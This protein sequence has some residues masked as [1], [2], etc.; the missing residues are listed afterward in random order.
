MCLKDEQIELLGFER[1]NFEIF[2]LFRRSIFSLEK[3]WSI[4]VFLALIRGGTL[5]IQTEKYGILSRKKN[6]S[7]VQ[8]VFN[9]GMRRYGISGAALEFFQ[10]IDAWTILLCDLGRHNDAIPALRQAFDF[11]VTKFLSLHNVFLIRLC[12]CLVCV[13]ERREASVLALE[14]ARKPYLLENPADRLLLTELAMSLQYAGLGSVSLYRELAWLY[15]GGQLVFFLRGVFATFFARKRPWRI[16]LL[17]SLDAAASRLVRYPGGS[18]IAFP[19][20]LTV[21]GL[22]MLDRMRISTRLETLPP[23]LDKEGLK[24]AFRLPGRKKEKAVLV[25][26]A[27]GGVGD[28]LMMTPGLA[29]LKRKFPKREVHFA[30]PK[31]FHPLFEGNPDVIVKDINADALVRDDYEKWYDL[32]DCPAGKIESL[33]APN[34]KRSRVE[35]FAAAMGVSKYALRKNGTTP[36]YFLRN[37]EKVWAQEFLAEKKQH[38][39]CIG[40]QPYSADLYRDYPHMSKLIEQVKRYGDII[41]FHNGPLDE[42]KEHCFIGTS[43]LSLRKSAALLSCC[44]YFIGIDSSFMHLAAAL[45]VPSLTIFGPTSGKVRTKGY[46]NSEYIDVKKIMPCVPCWR[47]ASGVCVLTGGRESWCMDQL[48]VDDVFENF[49]KFFGVSHA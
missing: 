44:S 8:S 43:N 5:A 37:E 48:N 39:C 9:E 42:F 34:V 46:V 7:L 45:K 31:S 4:H 26:R 47:N 11:G 29:A 13:G 10:M 24:G 2:S 16:K 19:F 14:Y 40:I 38:G 28:I 36:R 35:I 6:I 17:S 32:T 3:P 49:L 23:S 20:R 41:I 18:K 15:G 21:R 30:I 22:R 33:T 12:N 27:M 1:Q 25:T